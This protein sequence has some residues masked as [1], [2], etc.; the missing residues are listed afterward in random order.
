MYNWSTDTQVLKKNPSKF[1]IWKL[2]QQ[3]NFGLNNEK[4]DKSKLKKYF[5][6][7]NIDKDRKKY[8]EFLLCQKQS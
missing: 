6:K 4:I 3:I 2:E 1:A 5:N 7:L 8:L